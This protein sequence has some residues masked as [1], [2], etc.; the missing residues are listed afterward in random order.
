MGIVS[1]GS[2]IKEIQIM[3]SYEFEVEWAENAPPK[4]SFGLEMK[5]CSK[6]SYSSIRVNTV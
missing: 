4:L 2:R 1:L 5:F 6:M 3:G